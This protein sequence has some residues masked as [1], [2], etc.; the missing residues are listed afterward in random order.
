MDVET[1]IEGG[2]NR[3]VHQLP[4]TVKHPN[5][6]LKRGRTTSTSEIVTWCKS[7]FESDLAA[8]LQPKGL[9]VS[10]LDGEGEPVAEWQVSNAYPV[11]WSV[12]SFDAMRNELAIDSIELAY[13]RISRTL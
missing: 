7:V 5:L 10:L 8:P 3:F 13:T 1:I 9:T 12:G 4:K 6:K 2:E 11:K